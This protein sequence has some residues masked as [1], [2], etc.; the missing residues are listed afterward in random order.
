ME[1]KNDDIGNVKMTLKRYMIDPYEND[2]YEVGV[3]F[4]KYI[5]K[6]PVELILFDKENDKDGGFLAVY[7]YVDFII[8]I[9]GKVG[10][11]EK[12]DLC[13]DE[14][15]FEELLEYVYEKMIIKKKIW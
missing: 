10:C 6:K 11:G 4:F 3:G 2:E 9:N 8:Y 13:Q 12:F 15:L 7:R 5:F 14:D 1:L